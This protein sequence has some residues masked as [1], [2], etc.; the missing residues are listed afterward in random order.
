[1]PDGSI[2]GPNLDQTYCG[3]QCGCATGCFIE[4]VI[5]RYGTPN[6]GNPANTCEICSSN[7]NK[8]GWTPLPDNYFCDEMQLTLCCN[9]SCCNPGERCI[10]G[11]CQPN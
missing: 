11:G 2:C 7:Q 8:F 6:P 1:L 4:G 9:G 10:G 3:G 5:L